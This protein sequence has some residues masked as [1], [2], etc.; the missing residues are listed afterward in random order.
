MLQS[1]GSTEPQPDT[2]TGSPARPMTVAMLLSCS[3]FEEFYGRIQGLTPQRYLESYRGDWSWY[4]ARGLLENGIKPILYIPSRFED[5]LHETD[6]GI[7]V[8]FLRLQGW[9]HPAENIWIKRLVRRSRLSLYLDE[10]INTRAFLGSLTRGLEADGAD[11][12]Y[13]QEYW[14]GRFDYL[15]ERS[16]IPVVAADH[17]GVAAMALRSFK[18]QA[19]PKA[20]ALYCQTEDEADIV[21]SYGG[22][23]ELQ[24]NGCDSTQFFANQDSP[25]EKTVLTVTR[26]TNR[27]KRTSDLISAMA[28]LP[29]DWSLD[30]VGTGPDMEMLKR[31]AEAQKL[32]SRIR[33]RG[34]VGREDVRKYMQH[35]GVYSMPS[36]NEGIA[37]AS[38]EAMGS[39]AAV[40]FSRIRAFE[41][42]VQDGVNGRLVPVGDPKA[43]AAAILDAWQNRAAFG[44]AAAETIRQRFDTKVLY[45]QLAQSL[46]RAAGG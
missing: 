30:I 26:L 5:G 14:T 20:A 23:A 46:R 8:R 10:R 25:R 2:D 15:V 44:A 34:F 36:A 7:S 17:G 18:R 4:Y 31:Q 11:I 19:L 28:L 32:S 40:V 37:I 45:R 1:E 16:A 6:T 39:G 38:L 27:Q 21:R 29:E 9:Y 35:C 43:L 42:L 22:P 41:Y 3:S 24:P 13:L 33:F 12:L